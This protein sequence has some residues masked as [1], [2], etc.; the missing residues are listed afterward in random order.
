MADNVH[1][2]TAQYANHSENVVQLRETFVMTVNAM[3]VTEESTGKGKARARGNT[4]SHPNAALGTRCLQRSKYSY[5]YR[6]GLQVVSTDL[7]SRR[8]R[9]LT[10]RFSIAY[11]VSTLS[12]LRSPLSSTHL[13]ISLPHPSRL[14]GVEDE[15]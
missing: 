3:L 4:F 13:D 2:A 5:S 10:S 14:E 1:A 15:G 12:S 6:F 7:F 11:P 8:E 9:V